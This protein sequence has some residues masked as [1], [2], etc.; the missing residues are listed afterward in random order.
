MSRDEILRACKDPGASPRTGE[1]SG[2]ERTRTADPLL[3][4]QVLYRLSYVP[5]SACGTTLLRVWHG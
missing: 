5:M 3:A 4:K 2:D 1:S